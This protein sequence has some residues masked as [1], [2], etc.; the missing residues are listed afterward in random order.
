MTR[1]A[2][3]IVVVEDDDDVRAM[4]VEL[5]SAL[6]YA[7][8]EA[9]NGRE[10]LELMLATTTRPALVLLDLK[11]PEMD[12]WAFLRVYALEV[13]IVI[14]TA[15]PVADTTVPACAAVLRKPFD[16]TSFRTIV[17]RFCTPGSQPESPNRA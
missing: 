17:D 13:P 14:V 8:L 2:G 11:M 9:C 15:V 6:G 7:A 1:R 12:G 3:P 16:V 10:A 4:E 5:L